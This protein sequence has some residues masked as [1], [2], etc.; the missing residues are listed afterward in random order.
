[1]MLVRIARTWRSVHNPQTSNSPRRACLHNLPNC[2]LP[3]YCSSSEHAYHSSASKIE[4]P[5]R[6]GRGR[7]YLL[8]P[9]VLA[10]GWFGLGGLQV[11][12]TDDDEKEVDSYTIRGTNKVVKAG[13]SVLVKLP[14]VGNPLYMARIVK[15]VA[16]N[17]NNAKVRVRRYYR[18]VEAIGGRRQFHGSKDL[19]LSDQ[20]DAQSANTISQ[21]YCK[22]EM[23][24]NPDEF[25]LKCRKCFDWSFGRNNVIFRWNV[26]FVMRVVSREH[27]GFRVVVDPVTGYVTPRIYL[28]RP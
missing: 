5:I 16:D 27:I 19:F 23:P 9:A 2:R 15:I 4:V 3:N 21:K 24:R 1:M 26:K 7:Q 14:D 13:D 25:M 6:G 11:A 10:A 20:Y 22:C 8:F 28:V 17:Q 18:P 12:Y